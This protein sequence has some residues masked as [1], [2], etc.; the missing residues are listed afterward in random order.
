MT[1][2]T[3][4]Y[5]EV[6]DRGYRHYTGPR[7][8]AP[9]A[10]WALAR[11][12]MARALGIRRSWTAKIVPMVLYGAASIPVAIAIGIRAF[13]PGFEFL[14]YPSLFTAIFLLVGIFV[15]TVA[16][17][18]VSSDRHDRLLPLYFSRPIGRTS[19]VLA[20]LL[21]TGI[22]TL[23]IS[24]VPVVALWLGN[25][26]LSDEPLATM[27]AGLGDLGRIVLAG[28]MI[29]FYLG[30]IGLL[31]SSLTGRKSVAVGV[32]IL[33]FVLTESLAFAIAEA[34]RDQP[35]L[36]RW[37][38]VLSPSLTIA[39]MVDGLFGNVEISA[40]VPLFVVLAVMAAVIAS[41]CLTMFAWYRREL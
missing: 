38:F 6:F 36:E 12:S 3:S 15:A 21:A 16:P 37:I 35:D 1:A 27:R 17:E 40:D 23:T 8:G 22:L 29:S 24:L 26:L 13:V 18:M 11:Y 9:H 4:D 7:L 39:T 19:Y 30:A 32:I 10:I 33:G 5:G 28:A 25:G 31:I 41:C 20:K 34:L 14:D 2:S